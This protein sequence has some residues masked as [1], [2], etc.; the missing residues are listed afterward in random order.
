M[1]RDPHHLLPYER[2]ITQYVKHRQACHLRGLLEDDAHWDTTL[3]EAQMCKSPMQ[4][5]NLFSIML[6]NC[7]LSNPN[8]LWDKYKEGLS[9][10]ILQRIQYQRDGDVTFNDDIFNE[11]LRLIDDKVQSLGGNKLEIYGL[12]APPVRD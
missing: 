2:L 8:Q 5:R 3:T 7:G 1:S 11:T 4:L 9:E 10:D 6:V 12:P